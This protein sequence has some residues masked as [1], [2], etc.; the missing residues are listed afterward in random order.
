[1]LNGTYK[2]Y[3]KPSKGLRQGDPL[4]LYLFIIIE[5]IL[6][7]LLV[8]KFGEG[9]IGKFYH[10]R[11][12]PLVSHLLYVDDLLVLT[13]G[14]ARLFRRLLRTLEKYESWL[15][16]LINTEKYAIYFSKHINLARRRELLRISGFVEGS[17]PTTYLGVPL[18]TGRLTAR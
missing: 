15:G 17:F 1:M 2:S 13:N 6:S 14:D 9:R 8:T 7:H 4:S 12:A 11:G 18:V 3:F 16:Q 10:P 5:E